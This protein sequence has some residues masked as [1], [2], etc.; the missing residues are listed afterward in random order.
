MFFLVLTSITFFEA[1][2]SL[3]AEVR[4]REPLFFKKYNAIKTSSDAKNMMH[5]VRQRQRAL[6]YLELMVSLGEL[7]QK[8]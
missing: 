1:P 7:M 8:R 3:E 2:E 6:Q 4:K 5:T